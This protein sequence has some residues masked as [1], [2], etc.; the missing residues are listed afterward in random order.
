MECTACDCRDTLTI[1]AR[2]RDENA[3]HALAE[4]SACNAVFVVDT[5]TDRVIRQVKGERP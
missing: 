4:C 2:G 5:R 3:A 1:Y